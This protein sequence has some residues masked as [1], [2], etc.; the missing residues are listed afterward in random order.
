MPCWIAEGLVRYAL[1]ENGEIVPDNKGSFI[2]YTAHQLTE[3][4]NI[5]LLARVTTLEKAIK[6][7]SQVYD[8]PIPKEA[9]DVI[10]G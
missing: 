7:M 4:E 10:N 6:E 8:V 2:K 9:E 3:I 5:T 1:N